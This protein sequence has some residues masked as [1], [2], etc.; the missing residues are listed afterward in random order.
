MTLKTL[1][2]LLPTEEELIEQGVDPEEDPED[3]VQAE[4]DGLEDAN[5]SI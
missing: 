5:I 3:A 4:A 1:E 2:E